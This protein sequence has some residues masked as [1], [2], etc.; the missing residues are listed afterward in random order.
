MEDGMDFLRPVRL[1]R[2]ALLAGLV[3]L[4]L[5]AG[6]YGQD[7]KL[8]KIA[9][10]PFTGGSLDEQ[11][12]IPE[13]LSYSAE[14]SKNFGV[15]LRT[16]IARE[17]EW[18]Q[19]FQ[20]TPGM[21]NPNDAVT[22][23][24]NAGAEYVMTGSITALGKQKLL[25]VAII[26]LR[27]IRQVAGDFRLYRSV[28]EL[29]TDASVLNTM[30]ANLVRMV[31]NRDEDLPPLAVMPVR[32]E[33]DR[34]PTGQLAQA[35]MA[36]S[37]MGGT[38]VRQ[39]DAMAQVLAVYL[40][41]EGKW[42]VCPR[43]DLDTLRGEYDEQLRSG[44]T[45]QDQQVEAGAGL[46]PRHVLSVVSRTYE[47]DN[48]FNGSITNLEDGSLYEGNGYSVPYVTL[49]DGI[50]VMR[51]LAQALSGNPGAVD[52]AGQEI[53]V[54]NFLKNSGI[55]FHGWIGVNLGG[56]GGFSVPDETSN[57]T[58]NGVKSKTTTGWSGGGGIELRLAPF[59]GIQTGVNVMA[60]F[61]S[62]TP[63][64]ADEQHEELTTVQVP[65][66]ARFH[67]LDP[68]FG[69]ALL[70]G[71]GFNLSTGTSDT[72]KVNPAGLSLIL[73]G[74]YEF[75]GDH[76]GLLLGYQWN[77]DIDESSLTFDGASYNYTRGHHMIILN[78]KWYIPFRSVE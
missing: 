14:L 5:T 59:F 11:N 78:L 39:G 67:V 38:W 53:A 12:G 32:I 51:S 34:I 72:V 19:K 17:A 77:G 31:R 46:V 47:S 73:G 27:D 4:A 66:L 71:L 54:S 22:L 70:G 9:I 10:L 64:G 6:L 18:E 52:T 29:V 69:L 48:T 55:V 25:I 76:F 65:L 74:G 16:D 28:E 23:G 7:G 61:A 42:A 24:R 2:R 33:N 3:F 8:G 37:A 20:N 60:D 21:I 15:L 41:R 50:L 45:R 68:G 63:R 56:T 1:F 49:D 43:T 36:P 44:S 40:L 58:I 57:D 62:Y 13:R 35:G 75:T 30:A 26:D